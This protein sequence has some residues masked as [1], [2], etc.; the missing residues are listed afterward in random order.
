MLRVFLADASESRRA[1]IRKHLDQ[2]EVPVRVVGEASDGSLALPKIRDL[3][4]DVLVADADMPFMN[5]M[6]LCHAVSHTFPWIQILLTGGS[7]DPM[8][9]E[10]VRA[11]GAA[12]LYSPFDAFEFNE[13]FAAAQHRRTLMLPKALSILQSV[14]EE[15]TPERMEMARRFQEYLTLGRWHEKLNLQEM[16]CRLLLCY[17]QGE[18]TLSIV[19]ACFASAERNHIPGQMLVLELPE[20]IGVI[21]VH[22]SQMRLENTAYIIAHTVQTA[23]KQLGNRDNVAIRIGEEAHD[24]EALLRSYRA[25]RE[26]PSEIHEY[27]PIYAMGDVM[28]RRPNLPTTLNMLTERLCTAD[29][30]EL[31]EL[32]KEC[33]EAEKMTA[34]EIAA[35]C[36]MLANEVKAGGEWLPQ[37]TY[38]AQLEQL[39]CAVELRDACKPEFRRNPLNRARGYI[40]ANFC[41][42]T[43]MLYDVAEQS[44]MSPGRLCVLFQQELGWSFTYYLAY[45]RIYR[46]MRLLRRTHTRISTIAKSVGYHDHVYFENVFDIVTAMSPAE[47]RKRGNVQRTKGK[48]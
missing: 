10:N 13:V 39:R 41:N 11:I 16:P 23:V 35:G 3:Q 47:Y 43:L 31:P 5:G 14:E 19:R 45:M 24:C 28:R 6:E 4:P 8:Y 29:G 18:Q 17:T 33:R 38:D 32:L 20:G 37:G 30:E 21:L 22:Q 15:R 44:D 1:K 48:S 42:H 7:D 25:L 2:I 27:R 40:A 34:E 36:A 9:E 46:A 26:L 12:R